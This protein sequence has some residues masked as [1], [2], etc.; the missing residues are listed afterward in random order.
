MKKL[1]LY[2]RHSVLDTASNW[3]LKPVQEDKTYK[4]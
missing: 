4:I 3:I 2:N 1:I